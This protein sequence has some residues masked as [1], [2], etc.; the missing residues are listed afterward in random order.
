M[1]P[2]PLIRTLDL[3]PGETPASYVSR[4]ASHHRTIPREFCSDFGMRWPFLCSGQDDQLLGLSRLTGAELQQLQFWSPIKLKNG[5]YRV[6]G[7]ISSV[8]AFRRT[9]IRLCPICVGE[10]LEG[11]GPRAVFQL[12][13]WCVTCLHR[14]ETHGVALC[15]LPPAA[16]SHETYDV[17]SQVMRHKGRIVE[18]AA[19]PVALTASAFEAY[20]R[21]RIHQEPQ[22]DWLEALELVH[23]HR[24]CMTLG[25]TICGHERKRL[26][27]VDR[28]T[29]RRACD[30]GFAVLV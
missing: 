16:N 21:Q 19:R 23:L 5:R 26:I 24:A 3:L 14:C 9:S 28:D 15:A 6:G 22:D 20:I 30:A 13:E 7:A 12:L 17:V 11:P 2:A 27:D 25:L 29:E 8:G 4:L 18:A 10:A 1:S